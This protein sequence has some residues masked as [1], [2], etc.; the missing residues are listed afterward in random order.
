[1][2]DHE[3]A[4]ACQLEKVAPVRAEHSPDLRNDNV[5]K[6]LEINVGRKVLCETVDYPLTRF[7]H[8]EATFDRF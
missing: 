3:F 8:A 6:S 2:A 5:Q 7:M 4:V 1:M